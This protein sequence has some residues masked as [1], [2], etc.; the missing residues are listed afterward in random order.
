[1][2]WFIF[3]SS[4]VFLFTTLNL[5]QRV[6]ALNSKDARAMALVFNFIA[7]GFAILLFLVTG[8]Y[9]NFYLPEGITPWI[10]LLVAS[11]MYGLFERSR[12]Y[13]AKLL[14]ASILTI[15]INISVVVAFI[16]SLILYSETL[17]ARKLIGAA[18]I[19]SAL[20]I[21]SFK[22]KDVKKKS[23]PIKGIAL[24]VLI[25]V[26][27]GLGWTLDKMGATFFNAN[28][29]NI[30]IW[31][32]PLV[33]IYFPHIKLEKIKTELKIASWKIA[34]LA[35]LNVLGYFLQLK[36]LE[37]QEATRVIPIVQT[38][39]LFTVLLGIFILKEKDSIAK[40]LIASFIAVAG[41]YF[42][43]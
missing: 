9:K 3:A 23:A 15:I 18:L 7:S 26:F 10:A 24:G 35:F 36:A 22:R 29:Y 33:V 20:F 5:I 39:T 27:L 28:T 38:S 4:S 40:K 11:L 41:V 2:A 16:G 25:S 6:L 17:S 8:S 19:I 30:F 34:L 31:V 14:D 42:L 13:A 1:M 37:L 43:I 32:L 12:F 21:V